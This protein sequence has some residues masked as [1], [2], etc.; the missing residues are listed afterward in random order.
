MPTYLH[1]VLY[2]EF[3][4]LF[5]LLLLVTYLDRMGFMLTDQEG[6]QQRPTSLFVSWGFMMLVIVL[7]FA[8]LNIFLMR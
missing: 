3:V 8:P 5:S 4:I 1:P 2:S 7:V 6:N